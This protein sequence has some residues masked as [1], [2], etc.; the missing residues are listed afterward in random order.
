M[1]HNPM[2]APELSS[3]PFIR[4]P[5]I[6]HYPG[7]LIHDFPNCRF[8]ASGGQ[9]CDWLGNHLSIALYQCD[10]GGLLGAPSP[11]VLHAI[12]GGLPAYIGFINLNYTLEQITK[13]IAFHSHPDPV[14]QMPS[15]FIR[16]N[17]KVA[18]KLE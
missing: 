12:P 8:Q 6:R 5:F 17:S 16:M 11:L 13:R 10:H 14:S 15:A 4:F 3:Y 1:V 18:L 2:A 7:F 9:V